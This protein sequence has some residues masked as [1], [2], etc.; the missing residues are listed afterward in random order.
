MRITEAPGDKGRERAALQKWN[1]IF[2]SVSQFTANS[3]QLCWCSGAAGGVAPAQSTRMSGFSTSNTVVGALAKPGLMPRYCKY[4][5][6]VAHAALDDLS[7]DAAAPADH[8]HG[9]ALQWKHLP[10]GFLSRPRNRLPLIPTSTEIHWC[11]STL[12]V[13]PPNASTLRRA[14][15]KKLVGS[16][17]NTRWVVRSTC[18]SGPA[19]RRSLTCMSRASASQEGRPFASNA[20]RRIS[21]DTAT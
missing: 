11:D 15:S 8:D 4:A 2:T 14:N 18:D 12:S 3:S 20:C 17:P 6:A 13:V 9:F 1:A 19:V 10:S 16:M 5:R 21:R 7:S